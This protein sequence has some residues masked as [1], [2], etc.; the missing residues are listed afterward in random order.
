MKPININIK[1]YLDQKGIKYRENG[2]ELIA[3]CVF[4][5][6]D[7]NSRNGEAHLYFNS[8]TGQY[9]C[10]KCGA[11]GNLITLAEHFGD[12]INKISLNPANSKEHQKSSN[13]DSRLVETCHSALPIDIR[14]YLNARGIPD[15][16][17]KAYKLGYGEFYGKRW[18][19]IPIKDNLGN[20]SFLK[21]RQDPIFGDEKITF[22]SG[23]QAQLYDW[24]TAQTGGETLVVCEGEMDRLL[25]TS[26]GIPTVTSTHG[27]GTFKKEWAD[28]IAGNYKKI[29]ICF[30]NDEAGRKGANHA[31]K[32]MENHANSNVQIIALPQEV[33]EKGDITDYFV[34]LNGSVDDLFNKYAL[35]N[36][37]PNPGQ[38]TV[39]RVIQVAKPDHE[40]DFD[41]WRNVIASNF[42][43]LVFAAE[44]GMSIIAQILITEITNPFAL[45]LVDVPSAGKTIAI[46]FFDRIEGITYSSDKF[47]PAS[48]VSNATNVK[49]EK[50]KDIDLLPRL[51]YKMFLLR[52]LATLFSKRDDDL[53]ECLGLLTRVLDGEGLNTDGGVHGQRHY[54]GE[55]LFML[56]AASTPI[57]PRVW[58]IMGSL[59][60]RL[61]FLSMN[62]RKKSELELANQLTDTAYKEKEGVCRKTTKD[63]ILTLWHKHANGVEWDRLQDSQDCK[64]I[65]GRCAR[66]LAKLRGIIGVWQEKYDNGAGFS[67]SPPIIEM[68]DRINQLFYN[69][70]RGHALICNREQIGYDDLRLVVEIAIDSS[71]TIRARLF[72]KLL[73]NNGK[74]KTSEIEQMLQCSNPTALK[75][76]ETLKLLGLCDITQDSCGSVGGQEKTISLVE[77]FAWFLSDECKK[78]RG[79]L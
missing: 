73:D 78:I 65:V 17:I 68:P 32:L 33:G 41:E 35:K 51:Q 66:L 20:Y 64:L 77:E 79:I 76:M 18:I 27:A 49:K 23:I 59:G 48:F 54:N 12:D 31:A 9:D 13:F 72:R 26:K 61:F 14:Q 44:I 46:N 70:C 52:D 1:E 16:I 28:K 74:M 22:P 11:K 62:A 3:H 6:C 30:D 5:D 75:E 21:L 55:Y 8:Q 10:K 36:I 25:L 37:E 4:G 39:K 19:T 53:N 67:Y 42:P 45:V 29:Y 7:K 38:G 69:V 63:F 57:L 15:A 58:K 34:K 47:T 24:E 56:F 40:I 2:Q 60:S 43:D 50:L 71:P